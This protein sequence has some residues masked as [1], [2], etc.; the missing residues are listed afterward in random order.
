M[1]LVIPSGFP[2]VSKASCLSYG[3]NV[4]LNFGKRINLWYMEGVQS[5][6][7]ENKHS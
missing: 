6:Q 3:A 2:K 4:H 5:F 1:L 7:N